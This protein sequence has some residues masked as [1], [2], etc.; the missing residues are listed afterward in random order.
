LSGF[1]VKTETLETPE[2]GLDEPVEQLKRKV[3]KID[4]SFIR[5]EIGGRVF[6]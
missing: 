5:P 6:P 4:L 1:V 3:T 2:Q